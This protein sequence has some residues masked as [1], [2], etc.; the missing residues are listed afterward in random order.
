[1]RRGGKYRQPAN[2]IHESPR[3]LTLWIS[4]ALSRL[5]EFVMQKK[6]DAQ[7]SRT[8]PSSHGTISTWQLSVIKRREAIVFALEA[9]FHATSVFTNRLKTNIR[10]SW[11]LIKDFFSLL[12]NI[13][14]TGYGTHV[15]I[16][17]FAGNIFRWWRGRRQS[18]CVVNEDF[19][20][21]AH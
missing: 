3:K 15:P 17:F 11:K 19:M 13:W 7:A 12:H 1:M 10:C 6:W 9:D 16:P 18:S 2:E 4:R 14:S 5:S 8:Q 21:A 20:D